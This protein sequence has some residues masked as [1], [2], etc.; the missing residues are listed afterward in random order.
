MHTLLRPNSPPPFQIPSAGRLTLTPYCLHTLP[1]RGAAAAF[2]ATPLQLCN[3]LKRCFRLRMPPAANVLESF[4]C[5]CWSNL[6]P[7]T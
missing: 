4:P 1:L 7:G 2:M 6:S 5:K 3:S